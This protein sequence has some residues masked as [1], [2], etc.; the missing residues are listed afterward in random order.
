[1]KPLSATNPY[2]RNPALRKEMLDRHVYESSVFEGAQGLPKPVRSTR[3]K[4]RLRLKDMTEV[5]RAEY[6]PARLNIPSA[7]CGLAC[8]FRR[9]Q[10]VEDVHLRAHGAELVEAALA[11][12]HLVD[13]LFFF[14]FALDDL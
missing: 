7:P 5:A 11:D 6:G 3:S 13:H 8:F 14:V 12:L 1:M 4:D 10:A 9:R 2:L